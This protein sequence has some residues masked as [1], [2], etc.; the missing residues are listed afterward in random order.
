[1]PAGKIMPVASVPL[2]D[3]QSK[4]PACAFVTEMWGSEDGGVTFK[5]FM[6][7]NGFQGDSKG[8]MKDGTPRTAA[9]LAP[10][11]GT[12]TPLAITDVTAIIKN[13]PD[14]TLAINVTAGGG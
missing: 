6:G 7:S 13:I 3:A 8:L 12:S 11:F 5:R 2:T 9:L 4:D 10:W 1:M 14:P